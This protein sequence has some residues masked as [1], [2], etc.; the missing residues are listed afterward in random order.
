LIHILGEKD[1]IFGYYQDANM[2][3]VDLVLIY[4][5]ISLIPEKLFLIVSLLMGYDV[6]LRYQN[7]L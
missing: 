6:I 7:C 1:I 5:L 3:D 2:L 4:L